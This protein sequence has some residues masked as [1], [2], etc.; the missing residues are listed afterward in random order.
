M[1]L[2]RWNEPATKERLVKGRWM[3]MLLEMNDSGSQ[4]VALLVVDHHRS[5]ATSLELKGEGRSIVQRGGAG[6]GHRLW[7]WRWGETK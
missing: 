2:L 3:L 4:E 7:L 5:P 6:E 1:L